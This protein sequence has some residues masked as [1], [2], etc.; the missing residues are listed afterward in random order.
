MPNILQDVHHVIRDGDVE[1]V[2]ML[3]QAQVED[4]K[5]KATFLGASPDLRVAVFR[6]EDHELLRGNIGAF[7]LDKATL[8]DR[9]TVFHRLMAEPEL[10]P[11]L[12]GAL[13]SVGEYQ[14]QR[15][16]TRP[17]LFGTDSKRHD[18][19]WRELLTGASSDALR[20]I[21]EVFGALLDRIANAATGLSDTLTVI[22]NEFLLQCAEETK[23]DWRYYM[24]KYP[25]MREDGSSTYYAEPEEGNVRT[26]MGYSLCMLRAGGRALN[27]YYRD[28][29]LLAISRE[30][31]VG[32]VEDKWFMGYETEPRRL[33]LVKSG[34]A[35][36]CVVRGFEL[37]AP[38][39]DQY[40]EVFEAACTDLGVVAGGL[41]A[42]PQVSIDS[43]PVDTID[44]VQRGAELVRHL[45]ALGL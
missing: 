14:R 30:V 41:L 19:A 32:V 24:V 28:P 16:N 1:S 11:D 7:E 12:L 39:V 33:P 10:W 13:L 45:V 9:A 31:E 21:R 6:L 29:Y 35:L 22:T 8:E 36:R 34:V 37:S 44:R 17:F 42:V 43:R 40:T 20:S 23:F 4:E 15:A 25:S 27:G 2:T 26:S 38:P 3:K 18:N 5:R